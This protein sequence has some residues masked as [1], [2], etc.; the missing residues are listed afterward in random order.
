MLNKFIVRLVFLNSRNAPPSEAAQ[1]FPSTSRCSQAIHGER[2]VFI[3]HDE[4]I[5]SSYD[6]QIIQWGQSDMQT[7]R[8]KGKGT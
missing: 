4:S 5:F 7:I 1:W 8:P 2:N 3:F 6:H